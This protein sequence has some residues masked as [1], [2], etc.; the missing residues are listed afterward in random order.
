MLT[1]L[2]QCEFSMGKTLLVY[3]MNLKEMEN[4][5]A[6]YAD[7]G[8]TSSWFACVTLSGINV[9]LSFI[10]LLS[11]I[12]LFLFFNIEKSIT[13]AHEKIAECKKEIQRAKRIRKNRQGSV[14]LLWKK[15]TFCP[16]IVFYI[17]PFCCSLIEFSFIEYDALARVIKQHPDRHETL[18]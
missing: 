3:D 15:L 11:K 1:S 4:Y 8:K 7:I 14:K 2:A 9:S 13:S 17:T 6:I 5:E 16:F 18:K 12:F 10:E